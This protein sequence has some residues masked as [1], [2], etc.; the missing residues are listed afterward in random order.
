MSDRWWEIVV[1]CDP[2]MEESVYWQL[3]K[4]GCSGTATEKKPDSCSIKAYL[5]DISR[6]SLD[7]SNLSLWLEQDALILLSWASILALT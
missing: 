6:Q 7:I 2:V 3:E 4:F 5:S 1:I